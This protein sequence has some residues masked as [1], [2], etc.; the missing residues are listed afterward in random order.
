MRQ[1]VLRL[2]VLV[3]VMVFVAIDLGAEIYFGDIHAHSAYSGDG[4]TPEDCEAEG[5]TEVLEMFFQY[6]KDVGLDF[7]ALTDHSE[8]L[9]TTDLDNMVAVAQQ[10]ESET[11]IPFAGYEWTSSVYGHRSVV[12][13]NL[14]EG[15]PLHS[16]RSVPDILDLWEN[17]DNAGLRDYVFTIPHHPAGGPSVNDWNYHDADYEPVIEIYSE[18]GSFEDCGDFAPLSLGTCTPGYTVQDGLN[19][20]Y[21]Y[22]I[23][24]GTDSH[25]TSPGSV[26]DLDNCMNEIHHPYG[27]GLVAVF[28]KS[29]TRENIWK[30]FKARRVYATSGPKIALR[31]KINDNFMGAS[32]TVGDSD[33]VSITVHADADGEEA[34][35][36]RV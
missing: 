11:F 5:S 21:Q 7:V 15:L 31:F 29:L 23:I 16:S 24:A 12:F 25:D 2:C 26:D 18:F 36:E 33:T 30:A 28:A 1:N 19:L 22:G 9:S 4:G 17:Y 27:G 10:Y 20:G 6:A 14:E 8:G 32:I 34:V 13:K 3:L 35:I